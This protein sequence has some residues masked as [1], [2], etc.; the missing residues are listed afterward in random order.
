MDTAELP[1]LLLIA[2]DPRELRG[3]LRRCR[4]VKRLRWPVW[5]A[6]SGELNGEA[7][8]LVANGP[9]PQL[10]AEAVR[11]VAARSQPEAV[12]STG[13]CGALDPELAAGEVFVAIRVEGAGS[14][15]AGSVPEAG[16]RPFRMGTLVSLDRVVRTPAEKARLRERGAA[17]V[18]MEAGA[19]ALEA[20][21]NRMRFYC[22]RT[23]LD[24]AQEGFELD[25]D[26][27]RDA[28]GR[29]DRALIL[30]TALKRPWPC[31]PELLRLQRRS[32][33]G[34]RVLGEFLG[35]CKF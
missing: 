28:D 6:R 11:A 4:G 23:I 35:N 12:V 32:L 1:K 30:K 10:A 3:I 33:I 21:R 14:T 22:I 24:R 18:D 5:F 7:V 16:R 20:C 31:L 25:F 26:A 17:A 29:Y 27:L 15:Y 9:G 19:V 8:L 2:S 34:S 13:Y